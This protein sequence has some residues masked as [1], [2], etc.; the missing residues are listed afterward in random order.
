MLPP[1]PAP[2]LSQEQLEELEQELLKGPQGHGYATSLW[3]L[4][5]IAKLIEG[6][7]GV[8]HHPGR[9][10]HILRKMGWS[11]QKPQRRAKE[12]D[13]AQI[14]RW[15]KEDWPRIKRGLKRKER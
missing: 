8:R 10:W 13:E 6:L 5:R 1:G 4:P 11:C 15:V 9:V 2:L 12:K 3:T 14:A 7:F